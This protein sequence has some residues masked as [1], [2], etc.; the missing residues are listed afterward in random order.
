MSFLRS[1]VP[2]LA[3]AFA[4]FAAYLAL[5]WS[6]VQPGNLPGGAAVGTS[7][8]PAAGARLESAGIG[9]SH[10]PRS[11]RESRDL[12]INLLGFLPLGAL[13][14][15]LWPRLSIPRIT[16]ICAGLSFVIEAG[17]L[18]VPGHFPSV[19]DLAL[20]TLGGALGGWLAGLLLSRRRTTP[21]SSPGNP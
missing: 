20:N 11:T 13:L 19:V 8:S 12:L 21:A 17:Q 4:A 16:S 18:V 3:V 10:A 2:R 6:F 14:A 15:L 1:D 7:S 5:G 9:R